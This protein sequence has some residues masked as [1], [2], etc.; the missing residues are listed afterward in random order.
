MSAGLVLQ[1][2]DNCPPGVLGSW[3][4]LRGIEL[5]ILRVDRWD[6]L[7]SPTNYEFAVVL[8]SD[9][10]VA[11]PL[12]DWVGRLLK[13]L[14]EADAAGVPVLGICFGA[15]ALAVA[16]GGGAQRLPLPEHGWIELTTRAS[17]PVPRGPWLA[18]HEDS[19]VLPDDAS[20]LA[21]SALGPQ[22]FALRRHLGVQFHPEVTPAILRRWVADKGGRVSPVVLNDVADRCRRA[23]ANA[24]TLFDLFASRAAITVSAEVG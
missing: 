15:Q 20:L 17:S 21:R 6:S 2:Q 14:G 22:A 5:D 8:G 12:R 16:L 10:S 23:A 4:E 9:A 19:F 1:T 3:A 13:W 11:G 7:P 24:V 18:L